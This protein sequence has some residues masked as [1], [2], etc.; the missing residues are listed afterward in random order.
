MKPSPSLRYIINRSLSLVYERHIRLAQS[1]L[2]PF[3][4]LLALDSSLYIE[5]TDY[6]KWLFYIPIFV[7]YTVFAINIHRIILL[8]ADSV[9]KWGLRKWSSRELYFIFHLT[10]L[11]F[12]CIMLFLTGFIIPF[13]GLLIGILGSAYLFMRL[14]LVFPASAIDEGLTFKTSWLMTKKHQIL[15]LY[16]IIIV[17]VVF[18]IPTYLTAQITNA[19]WV[20][21]IIDMLTTIFIVS[22]LSITYEE[23]RKYEYSS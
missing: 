2:I 13:V 10:A 12:L 6:L 20:S 22:L 15:M 23:I 3:V 5:E 8:D 9:P 11:T 14:S 1:L 18:S 16:I 7:V 4:L 19:S 21:N 17:P